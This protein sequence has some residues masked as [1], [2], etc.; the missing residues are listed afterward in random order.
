VEIDRHA[1]ELEKPIKKTGKMTVEI[2]LHP[3]V[4][5]TLRLEVKALTDEEQAGEE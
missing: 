3:E 4:T 2:R 1:I 5:A